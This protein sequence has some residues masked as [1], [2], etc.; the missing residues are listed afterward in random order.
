MGIRL[1]P[2]EKLH[3]EGL[4][5]YANESQTEK[6]RAY[7]KHGSKAAAAKAL[8][9]NTHTITQ[10]IQSCERKARLNMPTDAPGVEA[11]HATTTLERFPLGEGEGGTLLQWTKRKEG[12][13]E[14]EVALQAAARALSETI[15]PARPVKK[16]PKDAPED[17]LHQFTITDYHIGERSWSEETGENW[18]V[19]IATDLLV[20][21]FE[22]GVARAGEADTAILANIGDFIHWDGM[23]ALTNQSGHVLDADTRI[24]MLQPLVFKLLPQA[25]SMLLQTHNNVHLIMAPGNHDDVSAGWMSGFLD[26]NYANEPRV[27]VDNTKGRFFAYEW[28]KTALFYHHG[29]KVKFDQLPKV[30]VQEFRELYGRTEYHYG[31]CG[32]YHHEKVSD[33]GLVHMTQHRTLVARDG[34]AAGLGLRA[35]REASIYTYHKDYGRAEAIH[36]SPAMVSDD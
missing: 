20:K 23:K 10:A 28:G 1:T 11:A 2:E 12:A 19:K 22:R 29:D 3:I 25:V 16:A 32:H 4:L 35:E 34:Y 33:N 13:A 24:K 7:L 17:L 36:L 21:W 26:A 6:L 15:K 8:D 30:F 14:V 9:R 31:H 18:D 5:A 27:T